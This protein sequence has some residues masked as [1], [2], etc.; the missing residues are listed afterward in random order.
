MK[1]IPSFL[2]IIVLMLINHNSEL[3]L[4]QMVCEPRKDNTYLCR[5]DNAWYI[6]VDN[7]G[8]F[9]CKLVN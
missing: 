7:N 3:L 1:I 6:C 2:S 8:T 9:E 4:S 5:L